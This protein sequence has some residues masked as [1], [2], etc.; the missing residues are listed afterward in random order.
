MRRTRGTWWPV[1]GAGAVA[2]LVAGQAMG[3]EEAEVAVATA[4]TV[5]TEA[6]DAMFRINNLWILIAAVLVF[7]MHLGFGC[8]EAGLTRAK[9]TVNILTKNTMIVLIG[10]L[11]YAVCGFNLMYPG[12]AEDGSGVFAWAG[13]FAWTG[14]GIDQ[15]AGYSVADD[16]YGKYTTYADFLFQAMFAATAATIVSGAVAGRVKLGPF[17]IFSTL[18]V[19]LAYPIAG[20]W[21]WGEGWLYRMGFADFAGSSIVHAFGGG[22]ALMGALILGP[23]LGKYGDDGSVHPIPGHNIPLAFIGVMVLWLGWFGFNGGSVL[24]ANPDG[25][26]QAMTTTAIAASSGGVAAYIVT[27]L[28]AGKPDLTMILNGILAGLVGITAGADAMHTGSAS[29]VGLIAGVI[30]VFSVYGFDKL[31]IDDPVGAI[32]VHGVCGIWGTLAVGI[33]GGANFVTQLIGT[34]SYFLFACIVAGILFGILK[35]M[36]QLRVSAEEEIEG[37]DLGE[38]DANAYPDFQQT[39]IKSYHA[40][41]L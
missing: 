14:E 27:R 13:M 2:A 36:G 38:H 41:E 29:I 31:K 24:D 1:L 32:S 25:V 26:S 39:Y 4:E 22:G 21:Q 35:A 12:F 17:L 9:N 10:I 30:V 8:L 23:R 33:F 18:F 37:L 40:G 11:M 15:T 19:G 6:S 7:S 20:S 5:A 28:L 3:Q 34:L 16:G